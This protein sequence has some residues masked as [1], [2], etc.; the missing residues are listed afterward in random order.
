MIEGLL[1]GFRLPSSVRVRI[2]PTF[3]QAVRA[4]D[5]CRGCR[6]GR[7]RA[8]HARAGA[9]APDTTAD[10]GGVRLPVAV[11]ALG[12]RTGAPHAHRVSITATLESRVDT[13]VRFDSVR[14]ELRATW[15]EPTSVSGW[16]RGL[17]GT[18]DA[19]AVAVG[20]DSLAVVPGL[21][22]PLTFAATQRSAQ[23]QP[24]FSA[25]DAASCASLAGGVVQG[26]R[27]LW[28][29]LPDT[30]RA[31]ATWRDSTTYVVCRDSIPLEFT[32]VRT[33]EVGQSASVGAEGVVTTIMRR[34]LSQFRGTGTQFGEPVTIEGSGEG[35]MIY[36]V[37]LSGARVRGATGDAVLTLTLRGSRRVQE[38]TQRSRTEILER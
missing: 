6:R 11:R 1:L 36:E 28:L 12:R 15:R 30:L 34:T 27:D 35:M 8:R 33:F 24:E 31:G 16:P 32:V 21:P 20:G 13:V 37:G 2:P 26:V 18:I 25:P 5:R 17:I 22:L 7:V 14:S 19:Y 38:L 4:R 3:P 23:T 10:R 9:A 29:S